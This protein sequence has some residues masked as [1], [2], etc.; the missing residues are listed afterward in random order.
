M[1]AWVWRERVLAGSNLAYVALGVLV[2]GP[3]TFLP[4]YAQTVLGYGAVAARVRARHDEHQ[5]AA[6]LGAV[7]PAVPADRLPR[8]RR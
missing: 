2:I 7:Q 3:S 5:L 6:G 8:H 1:P 4:T